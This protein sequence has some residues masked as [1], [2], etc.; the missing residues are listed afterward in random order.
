M[1]GKLRPGGVGE[2]VV[3][4]RGPDPHFPAG[5][6]V[7]AQRRAAVGRAVL[8]AVILQ[9]HLEPGGLDAA[10]DQVAKVLESEAQD[11]GRHVFVGVGEVT[12]VVPVNAY[13]PLC[14]RH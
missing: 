6:Q 11:V 9:V 7:A 5:L 14:L 13:Q 3:R 12:V 4:I 10:A 1:R 8:V 2:G